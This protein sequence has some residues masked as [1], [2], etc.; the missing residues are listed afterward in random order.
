MTGRYPIR[1][2]AQHHV[3]MPWM[4]NGNLPVDEVMLPKQLK[5][6][7]YATHGVGKWH[8]GKRKREKK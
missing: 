4:R 5:A 6:L 2:G 8:L 1:F 3:Y 7:G